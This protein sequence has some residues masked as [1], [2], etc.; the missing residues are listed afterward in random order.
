MIEL[1]RPPITEKAILVRLALPDDS[2][3]EIEDSMAEMG[4]LAWTA[5]ADTVLRVVQRRAAPCP[6]TLIGAG[7]VEEIRLA[8]Q[9]LNAAIVL[10][11]S[12]LS[13]K[14]STKLSDAIGVKVI[15]RTQLILDIFAQ[16]AHTNE[17]KLQ[18]ELAQ[19]E[20]ALPRLTGHGIQLM[21]QGAGIGTRGPGEKKLEVDRRY[22]R[23]RINRLKNDL[24]HV[25]SHRRIQRKRRTENN[26]ATVALVGYTNAGKSSL[27][28]ALTKAN[29]FVEDRLFATLDP[30]SRRVELPSGRTIILTDTVGF[31]RKLPH[32]LVASFRA[33]L[34]EVLEA[35]LLLHVVDGSHHAVAEHIAAVNMVLEEIGAESK[36]TCMVY[37]KA[38]MVEA[39]QVACLQ[40]C[41]PDSVAVSAHTGRG[42]DDLLCCVD[43]QLADS[44]Q[45]VR[46]RIP[47]SDARVIAKL[48][49]RG[50]VLGQSYEGNVIV[51]EAELDP[52]LAGQLEAYIACG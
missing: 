1:D 51:V 35:D 48:H 50:R 5:G 30:T 22:I 27:L 39:G 49:D 13:P 14:Q 47:Q 36:P 40:T 32:G 15:D 31:I 37:N 45:R 18:V 38:D 24:E 6:A 3:Q 42:L 33:T 23:Q 4:R 8:A 41:D 2:E 34:E 19:L 17:G 43:R 26:V 20:Y 28:N 29:V 11:D 25:R 16:R 44:R 9:E 52:A 46:L 21:Q 10:V 7:K 12:E